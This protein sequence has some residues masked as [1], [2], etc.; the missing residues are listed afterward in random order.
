MPQDHYCIQDLPKHT[1]RWTTFPS[2]DKQ[3]GYLDTKDGDVGVWYTGD[4]ILE[5]QAIGFLR[6]LSASHTQAVQVAYHLPK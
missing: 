1:R 2:E 6:G 5:P 3:K 4:A